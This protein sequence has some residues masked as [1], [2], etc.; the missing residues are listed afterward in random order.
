MSRL[1]TSPFHKPS[2]F[3]FPRQPISPPETLLTDNTYP[4]V[5]VHPAT[6]TEHRDREEEH[7]PLHVNHASIPSSSSHPRVGRPSISYQNSGFREPPNRPVHRSYRFFVVVIPPSRLINEH[8]QLGHTLTSGPSHR[9]SQGIIM[10]LFPTVCACSTPNKGCPHLY[11][12]VWS[13]R[14]YRQGI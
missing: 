5:T 6:N 9:L 13:T 3:T 14:G 10:P 8:G 7:I 2:P 1:T 4:P 12:D 11:L